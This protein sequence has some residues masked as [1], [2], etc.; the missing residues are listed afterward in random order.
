[1]E[2][3]GKQDIEMDDYESKT[4]QLIMLIGSLLSRVVKESNMQNTIVKVMLSQKNGVTNIH[5]SNSKE[6]S[7]CQE[8]LKFEHNKEVNRDNSKIINDTHYILEILLKNIFHATL[9]VGI[10]GCEIQIP[11]RFS[12]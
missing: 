6:G 3:Y 2:I 1:M 11:K 10:D 4:L 9:K 12:V 8:I 7:L 5:F